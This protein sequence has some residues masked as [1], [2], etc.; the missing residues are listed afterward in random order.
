MIRNITIAVLAIVCGYYARKHP[1]E[2]LTV[3][4]IEVVH[5][6]SCFIT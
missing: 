4:V 5:M 2:P 6:T 3:D 1:D